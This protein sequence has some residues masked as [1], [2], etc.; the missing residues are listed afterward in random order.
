MTD[1]VTPILGMCHVRVCQRLGAV[2]IMLHDDRREVWVEGLASANGARELA[3]LLINVA[4]R[5]DTTAEEHKVKTKEQLRADHGTPNEFEAACNRAAND[6]FL[7]TAEATAA[8]SRYRTAYEAAPHEAAKGTLA[9][10]V[11]EV[12]KKE[13]IWRLVQ[14]DAF[15]RDGEPRTKLQLDAHVANRDDANFSIDV[16]TGACGL[17]SWKVNG[18]NGDSY[19]TQAHALTAEEELDM[20]KKQENALKICVRAVLKE[21]INKEKMKKELEMLDQ[22]LERRVFGVKLWDPVT[23][24]VR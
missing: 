1:T 16:A 3:Q 17:T 8:V 10:V 11:A 23:G 19:D 22:E 18:H 14:L 4:N 6:R 15:I 21:R 5:L 2:S 20:L 12:T 7:T 9:E 24:T 13:L